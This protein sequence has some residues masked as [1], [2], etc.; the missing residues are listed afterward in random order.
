M[1]SI[2]E[3]YAMTAKEVCL[4]G[5]PKKKV[6][7]KGD[8]VGMCWGVNKDNHAINYARNLGNIVEGSTD[9]IVGV[10][11]ANNED[12]TTICFGFSF[13]S[14]DNRSKN[15][16]FIRWV[17][18][19]P[20]GELLDL[21]LNVY[22]VDL[23]STVVVDKRIVHLIYNNNI[24]YPGS[25]SNIM[26]DLRLAICDW[27][28]LEG[29]NNDAYEVFLL[30]SDIEKFKNVLLLKPDIDSMRLLLAIDKKPDTEKVSA[31]GLRVEAVGKDGKHYLIQKSN[32]YRDSH[33]D[34]RIIRPWVANVEAEIVANIFSKFNISSGPV[35]L[36]Q[37]MQ[38]MTVRID[39][40]VYK[41]YAGTDLE[42]TNSIS[43]SIK[44]IDSF[45]GALL[46]IID[47]FKLLSKKEE[48]HETNQED[49]LQIET[50]QA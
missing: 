12:Q 42:L 46:L 44:I 35:S 37:L 5:D 1:K 41:H 38:S 20:A 33:G 4:A 47:E 18:G 28:V 7:K 15:V 19:E 32:L 21:F 23:M 39:D 17:S 34:K 3:V 8:K 48:N 26:R 40:E 36:P 14:E 43:D 30:N 24:E 27:G 16:S 6:S 10:D 13:V 50:V 31:V 9:M 22:S 11:W 29:T 45:F 2:N 25:L 49:I